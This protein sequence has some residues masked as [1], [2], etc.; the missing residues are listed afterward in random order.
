MQR[1]ARKDDARVTGKRGGWHP[2]G[3]PTA[4]PW[5]AHEI[6]GGSSDVSDT[7][8]Q[9]Q[10]SGI[11]PEAKMGPTKPIFISQ[12]EKKFSSTSQRHKGRKVM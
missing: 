10:C 7:A 2:Q 3:P 6:D 4:D 11:R 5:N 8:K 1:I 9:T 12:G